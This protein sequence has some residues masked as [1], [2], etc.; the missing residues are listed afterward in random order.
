MQNTNLPRNQEPGTNGRGYADPDGSRRSWLVARD[1][2][3][4]RHIRSVALGLVDLEPLRSLHRC[5]KDHAP[6]GKV[7]FNSIPHLAP[8]HFADL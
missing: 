7:D 1:R 6:Q 5:A 8:S 2:L 4:R 3:G